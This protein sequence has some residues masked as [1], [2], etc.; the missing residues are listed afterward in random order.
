ME[1]LNTKHLNTK[2]TVAVII[3]ISAI[4]IFVYVSRTGTKT[5]VENIETTE[6]ITFGDN[7]KLEEIRSRE[8]VQHQQ[9]LIVQKIYLIEKREQLE[10]KLKEAIEGIDLEI[11]DVDKELE[12]LREE[13][14]SF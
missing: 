11:S 12:F 10:R 7:K 8:E 13:E 9:E 6:E 5:T 14:L 2:F 3:V 1:H 4:A